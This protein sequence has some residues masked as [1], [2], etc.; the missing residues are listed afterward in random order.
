MRKVYNF[1]AGPAMLPEE[2]LLQAQAEMLDWHETGMSIMEL[3]HRGPEF[4]RVAEKAEADLREL[5]SIP[6]NYQVLFLA[7]GATTQFSMVPLNLFDGKR[8]ADYVDTG[9]WSKKAI[10]EASRYGRVNVVAQTQHQD[11]LDYIP[12]QDQWTMNEDAV[13]LH[14][15]PNETIGGIEFQWIPQTGNVPLVA[16]MTSMILSRPVNVND[17]GIIYAGAQ[18]NIGQAGITVV[19]I[20]EDLIKE[21]LPKTPALYSYKLHAEHNSF[22]NTPPTYSWYISG[23]VLAWMKHKGGVQAFYQQNLRKAKTLYSLIDQYKD[24]YISR[25]HPD[26]R[27]L[28]NVMFHLCNETLTPHFLEEAEKIGLTNLRGHRVSG[29]VRASIYNAMPED[30]VNMLADF[31]M[32]FARRK[33]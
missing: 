28:M 16:D 13:Y 33:G 10:A 5:M 23:L 31:M 19:I 15:T 6:K 30:G 4:K 7:G 32:D 1:S 20:R 27:S 3:G 14:Y 11:R 24:F 9:I 8:S 17:Y 12:A 22:Y 25:V 18:K 21:P 2:V 26:C 29:G